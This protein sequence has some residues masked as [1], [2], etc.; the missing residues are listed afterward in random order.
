MSDSFDRLLRHPSGA[1]VEESLREA[2][3]FM[4]DRIPPSRSG[5]LPWPLANLNATLGTFAAEREGMRSWATGRTPNT[6]VALAWWTSF[7]G[8]K[9]VRVVGVEEAAGVR[10]PGYLAEWATPFP[11]LMIAPEQACLRER[12]RVR[13]PIVFCACGVAGTPE[14]IGWTGTCCGPCHD[15]TES[16]GAPLPPVF[17]QLPWKIRGAPIIALAFSPDSR[18]V[19]VGAWDGGFASWDLESGEKVAEAEQR[20]VGAVQLAFREDGIRFRHS[21]HLF[22]WTPDGKILDLRPP[23]MQGGCV[24]LA[25]GGR[26]AVF[27][28][29]QKFLV[30]DLDA[31]QLLERLP[32]PGFIGATLDRDGT[33]LALRGGGITLIQL[34]QGR[35][36]HVKLPGGSNGVA[37]HPDGTRLTACE[38]HVL[39]VRDVATGEECV[40]YWRVD[41]HVSS[42]AWTPD[43]RA[44][45][46]CDADGRV[47]FWPAELLR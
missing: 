32:A 42:L 46:V 7:L 40:S 25:P 45:V 36:P 34:G 37:F 44:L 43:G 33:V 35:Q 28:E 24:A 8:E 19:V 9:V 4:N 26:I 38:G 10:W 41:R 13:E 29:R 11:L 30:W 21:G 15:H 12:E 31:E 18:R 1:E 17:P 2:V 6:V 22:V 23:Q 3:Q 27:Y 16:T 20:I 5:R 47:T 14:A 39:S